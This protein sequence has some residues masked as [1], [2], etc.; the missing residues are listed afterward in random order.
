MPHPPWH[1]AHTPPAL[2]MQHDLR[3]CAATPYEVTTENARI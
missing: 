2:C 1:V 3:Q